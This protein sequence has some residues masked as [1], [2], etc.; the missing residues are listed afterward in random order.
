MAEQLKLKLSDD[1]LIEEATDFD[2]EMDSGNAKLSLE[3]S[4]K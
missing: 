3:K 4:Q 1:V 2:Q